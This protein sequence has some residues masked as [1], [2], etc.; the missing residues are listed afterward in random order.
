[1]YYIML[2]ANLVHC[3]CDV[4]GKDVDESR[5]VEVMYPGVCGEA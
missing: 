5:L 1:V 4:V 2:K 3:G